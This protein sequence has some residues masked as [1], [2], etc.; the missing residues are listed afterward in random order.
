MGTLV[1]LCSSAFVLILTASVGLPMFIVPN[2]PDLSIKTRQ[3]SGN[4][5]SQVDT[6]YLRGARQR[7][8]TVVEKPNARC[9]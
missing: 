4:W 6:L 9:G 1:T 3:T 7:T 2:H 8:E 5:M